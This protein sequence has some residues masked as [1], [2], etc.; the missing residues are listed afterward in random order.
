MKFFNIGLAF[1]IMSGIF[2]S[3]IYNDNEKLKMAQEGDKRFNTT[4]AWDDTSRTLNTVVEGQSV[5][6]VFGFTNTGKEPFI[7]SDIQASCGC[8]VPEKPTEPIMP[9][10]KGFIRAVFNSDGRTGMNHK[11]ISVISNEY[12]DNR[13]EL[14]FNVEVKPKIGTVSKT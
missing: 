12:P 5:E 13:R 4:V 1:L 7:I 14:E 9:G 6:V 10:K 8:T 3:C 11:T 2:S